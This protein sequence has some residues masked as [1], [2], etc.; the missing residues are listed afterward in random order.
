MLLD[1]PAGMTSHDVVQRVR[2]V[3]GTRAAG[4]T[5]TLD[6]FATGLLVVL[7]GRATRLARFVEAQAKTYLATARLGIRT[8]TDDRTGAPVGIEGPGTGCSEAQ[9]R[10]TLAG[11]A[12][13][14]QQR[15]PSY[16]AKHVDGE[17]SYRLARRGK[18]V[19]PAPVAVTVH[20]IELVAW[21]APE[22]VFR[23]TVSPGTY[24]RAIARDLGERLGVGAHLTALRR[25]AIGPLRVEDAVSLDRL[26]PSDLL[27]ARAVLRHLPVRE[28]D[29]PDRRAVS[30]GRAVP[31]DPAPAG[32]VAL[33]HGGELVAVARA[34]DGWL[35]PSVV[36]GDS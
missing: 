20:Q 5:G 1:K 22:L 12:G 36:L 30:H 25:E 24:L 16:S 31:A 13:E 33:L 3:L 34:V 32:D 2:R 4:H 23:A 10:Q 15:P 9:V 29:E 14:Q 19:A 6:P 17:R 8:D 28:L 35:R 26:A 21:A 11:F 18:D 7:V 27:P